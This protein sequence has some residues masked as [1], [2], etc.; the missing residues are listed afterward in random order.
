MELKHIFTYNA[1]LED[2][3]HIGESHKGVRDI[4]RIKGG[5]VWGSKLNG[6]LQPMGGEFQL[7]DAKG[8]FHMD[9]RLVIE[10]DDGVPI[11]MQYTG[12]FKPTE[13][14]MQKVLDNGCT[15]F[16]DNYFVSR[17]T[18]ETGH[19]K[20]NWLNDFVYV[21]EGRVAAPNVVE[22]RVCQCLPSK[23]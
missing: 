14:L 12:T 20:Y 10:T 7:T 9:V 18:I 11:Y 4:L 17:P 2:P 5:K 16:G 21:A 23:E 13:E 3:L 15:E 6:Q 1:E 22:Y 19:E 8:N